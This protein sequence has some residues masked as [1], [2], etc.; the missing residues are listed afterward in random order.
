ML[1]QRYW[2][3]S[4]LFPFIH[5][6]F[7]FFETFFVYVYKLHKSDRRSVLYNRRWCGISHKNDWY[8]YLEGFVCLFVNV[9]LFFLFCGTDTT[10]SGPS[11]KSSLLF[12]V[13]VVYRHRVDERRRSLSRL[14]H[15]IYESGRV[16]YPSTLLLILFALQYINYTNSCR[17]WAFKKK[18]KK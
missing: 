13:C 18:K 11:A 5:Y 16:E 10:K 1:C 2:R 3:L 8:P 14:R 12:F 17:M 9:F 4:Y 15:I 6:C 7:F